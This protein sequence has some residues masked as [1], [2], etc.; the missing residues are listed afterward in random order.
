MRKSKH[1]PDLPHKHTS[2]IVAPAN[3]TKEKRVTMAKIITCV[4]HGITGNAGRRNIVW[5][6]K[7]NKSNQL[8]FKQWTI[9]NDQ[10]QQSCN[11]KHQNLEKKKCTENWLVENSCMLEFKEPHFEKP[12]ECFTNEPR[13]KFE[14]KIK[15]SL[16]QII[17]RSSSKI[18]IK[19]K[20]CRGQQNYQPV[21]PTEEYPQPEFSEPEDDPEPGFPQHLLREEYIYACR[22]CYYPIARFSATYDAI[23]DRGVLI[24]IVI[25]TP[26]LNT[27]DYSGQP[28][29][30]NPP[31]RRIYCDA[32]GLM[33]TFQPDTT[34][35]AVLNYR[36]PN[37][38][39]PSLAILS[40]LFIQLGEPAFFAE[41]Y[42]QTE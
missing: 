17:K 13:R 4:E 29:N 11:Q 22:T 21:K 28:S 31:E 30:T 16:H 2:L 14:N 1:K 32:C 15:F 6:K 20:M 7:Q 26:D 42:A 12:S 27:A 24:G 40:L 23:Y 41:Q 8:P 18:K 38:L 37:Q 34:P 39:E 9:N 5:T 3:Q 19:K 35:D 10:L 33:L 25:P 36:A